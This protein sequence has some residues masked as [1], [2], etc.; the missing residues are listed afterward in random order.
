MAT[1]KLVRRT[2]TVEV[3]EDEEVPSEHEELGHDEVESDDEVEEVVRPTKDRS[4]VRRR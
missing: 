2:T 4:A 1:N 3:F